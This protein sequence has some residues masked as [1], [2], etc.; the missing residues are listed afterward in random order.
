MRAKQNSSGKLFPT[1]FFQTHKPEINLVH[2]VDVF[3]KEQMVGIVVDPLRRD[4]V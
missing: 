4:D 2:A 1:F 3:L